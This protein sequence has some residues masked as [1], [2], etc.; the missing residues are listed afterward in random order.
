M[1]TFTIEN[2]LHIKLQGIT[3]YELS[4]LK[5][6]LKRRQEGYMF[7]PMY[8]RKAWDGYDHFIIE[9]V[10]KE[11]GIKQHKIGI[12][13]IKN[14]IEVLELNQIQYNIEGIDKLIDSEIEPTK[15]NNFIEILLEG[16]FLPDG[17]QLRPRDYQF[18]SIYRALKYKFCTQELATSAGKTIIFYAYAAYLKYKKRIDSSKKMLI[19]VPKVSLLN[20]T[21][22]AFD[23]EYNTGLINLKLMRVGDKFKFKQKEFDECEILISTYQSLKNLPTEIYKHFNILGIDEAHSSKGKTISDIIKASVNATYKF[24]LSGT[25]ELDKKFSTLFK[26]QEPI[27]AMRLI[28][29][30]A[31]LQK[32]G[33][34]PNIHI[35]VLKLLHSTNQFITDYSTLRNNYSDT[36][37]PPGY[38]DSKEFGKAMF[39]SEKQYLYSS[40][41]RLD[42]IN[43]LVKKLKGNTLI[44]FNN[45]K[46]QYGLKIQATLSE[47]N[48]SVYYIDG[49]IKIKER[50]E[51]TKSLEA[52]EGVIIVASYGTFAT[53][54]NLKRLHN[55]IFAESSKS[56]ITIRQSIGRG[57]RLY[58]NKNIVNIFDLVDIF[59]GMD[60]NYMLLH[61]NERIK[62]YKEQDFKYTIT[63]VKF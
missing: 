9:H 31:F 22:E 25:L 6:A 33:Y 57:M 4:I 43:N 12:G 36:G 7:S 56:E 15:L 51:F 42:I 1:I 24:G 2:N 62:I 41:R 49:S 20:Q 34:S 8:K 46:D 13:M 18:E 23:Q 48:N 21:Y 39:E 29:S 16:V 60:N 47:H 37:L 38:A 53:G 58:A 40:D 28:V 35:K 26:I 5:L 32:E 11:S 10:D 63:E 59:P 45:I 44:L 14:A 61:S 17:S 54:L 19:I 52:S 27:G 3:K 30:S 55:I 50:E